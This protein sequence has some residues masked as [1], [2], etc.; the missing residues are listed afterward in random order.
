[1]QIMKKILLFLVATAFGITTLA[2]PKISS[3][4]LESVDRQIRKIEALVLL[5]LNARDIF[6]ES[7]TRLYNPANQ[8]PAIHLKWL[9]KSANELSESLETNP[10]K[11]NEAVQINSRLKSYV[12]I[13]TSLILPLQ[14]FDD[15]WDSNSNTTLKYNDAKLTLSSKMKTE[16]N[17]LL[18]LIAKTKTKS[19]NELRQSLGSNPEGVLALVQQQHIQMDLNYQVRVSSFNLYVGGVNWV[20]TPLDTVS[21][22]RT[23]KEI[24]ET[25]PKLHT[26]LLAT[27]DDQLRST[28]EIF[29]R[30]RRGVN[31]LTQE[32]KTIEDHEDATTRLLAQDRLEQ[33]TYPDYDSLAS[34]LDEIHRRQ[35]REMKNF[36]SGDFDEKKEAIK[37]M[38]TNNYKSMEWLFENTKPKLDMNELIEKLVP[39][40]YKRFTY[41]E[42]IDIIKFQ[43]SATGTKLRENTADIML[44]AIKALKK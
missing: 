32:L 36:L 14:T 10:L 21:M 4:K 7:A 16:L 39:I 30:L 2:Q 12:N 40:Y 29:Y 22:Q 15:F 20:Y 3:K 6:S 44:E 24:K 38:I 18:D 28:V 35:D 8:D 1:M 41:E 11:L 13:V 43:E 42:I 23:I 27:E 19:E 34:T 9:V 17:D 5:D 26:Q 33:E 25:S 37:K 31:E